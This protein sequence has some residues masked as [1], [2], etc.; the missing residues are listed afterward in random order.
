MVAM[1]HGQASRREP[2]YRVAAFADVTG[3]DNVLLYHRIHDVSAGGLCFEAA[4]AED[5]G[6]KIDVLLSFPRAKAELPITGEVVWVEAD[7]SPHVGL[8][9]VNLSEETRSKLQEYISISSTA[10]I[11]TIDRN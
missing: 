5:V 2:R 3:T 4:S 1:N 8:R 9:W 10:E 6:N 11:S 7:A